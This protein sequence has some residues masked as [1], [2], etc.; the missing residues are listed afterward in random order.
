MARKAKPNRTKQVYTG[1]NLGLEDKPRGNME[2]ADCVHVV[3][4]SLF[5]EPMRSE[6][7]QVGSDST[8]TVELVG[9][10]SERFRKVTLADSDI[11]TLTILDSVFSY[12][13]NGHLL[14]AGSQRK[15]G[16]KAATKDQVGQSMNS[17]VVTWTT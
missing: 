15:C 11:I 12:D 6:T 3:F 7:S 1:A 9:T 2:A 8:R 14:R 13:G 10:Q 5:N 17:L 16:V 4:G